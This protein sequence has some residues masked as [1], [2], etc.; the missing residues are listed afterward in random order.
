MRGKVAKRIRDLCRLTSGPTMHRMIGNTIRNVGFK[1]MVRE[2][3]K[4][5]AEKRHEN[6]EPLKKNR[7]EITFKTWLPFEGWM[8]INTHTAKGESN[9]N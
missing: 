9:G 4:N 7:K 3:K 1:D 6:V 2:T 5:L 8:T